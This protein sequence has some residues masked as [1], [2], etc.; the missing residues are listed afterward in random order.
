M[1]VFGSLERVSVRD[2]WPSEPSDFTPWL[3]EA[4]NLAALGREIKIDLELVAKE[5]SV[6]S[7]FC[8]ILARRAGTEETVV[9]ENQYGATDH[10]H[11][12]QLLTYAAGVGADGAGARA[13]VWI[14]EQFNEPHRAALDWLNKSTEPGIRF[15]GVEI[16]L[17]RIGNSALAPKFNVV[18]RPNDWQKQITQE[19]AALSATEALYQEFWAG[20]FDFCAKESTTLQ[21]SN[22]PRKLWWLPTKI[23]SPGYGVNLTVS[24]RSKRLECQLWIEFGKAK[25]AFAALSEKRGEIVA[26]LGSQV[27]FDEM[28]GK[29]P[30]KIFEKSV[31]DVADREQWPAIFKWLKERGEAY[32]DLFGPLVKLLK[33]D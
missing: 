12:G 31:G 23:D 16:Q 21:F 9:I 28:P 8:D 2:G 13:I 5:V 29:S 7:Y 19:T 24:A 6:G 22:S 18:S 14:A 3:A 32:A 26:R 30:C 27:E 1:T 25:E 10:K 33:L 20:F 17:W 4:A 15:F 11:L